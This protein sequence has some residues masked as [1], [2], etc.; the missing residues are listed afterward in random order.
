M[1]PPEHVTPG[2]YIEEI[3]SGSRKINAAPTGLTAFIGA[4]T[5]GPRTKAVE[6]GSLAEFERHFGRGSLVH[7]ALFLFFE[8]GGR[9]AAIVRQRD[10]A[11]KSFFQAIHALDAVD[12]VNLVCLP[13]IRPLELDVLH[14]AVDYCEKRRA[15]LILDSDPGW[16]TTADVIA[17]VKAMGITSPNAA[18]FYPRLAGQGGSG[19]SPSG[20]IAGVI[21]RTDRDHGVWKAPAGL[22]AV[23]HGARGLSANLTQVQ[24]EQLKPAQV[25]CLRELQGTGIVIWGGRTLAGNDNEWRYISVR[26]TFLFIEESIDRGTKWAVFEPNG[27]P[28]WANLRRSIE[29]FLLELFRQG[30]LQGTKPE[31]AFFVR[32]DRSTMTDTDIRAGKVNVLVGFAPIKP[33]EFVIVRI[34]LQARPA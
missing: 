33:A 6:V 3:P 26:R 11:L 18:L 25:N 10:D 12:D 4:M 9:R 20:A 2:V 21:A 19:V 24:I 23:L 28:L 8:N 29:D 5:R 32:C 13:S 31:Q 7:A 22:E 34:S 15:F 16:K 17:G 27:E 14:K 1:I 30:G